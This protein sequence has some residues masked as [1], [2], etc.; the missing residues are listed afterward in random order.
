MKETIAAPHHP[1]RI[2]LREAVA[3]GHFVRQSDPNQYPIPGTLNAVLAVGQIVL[4]FALL[5]AAS[6]ASTL[7]VTALFA[8]AFAFF[9]QL[10][11]GL[12]HEAA[13]SKLHSRPAVNEGLGILS[14]SLFPGSY[15]LFEIAHLVHHR[16]NRSD[17]F[18]SRFR[19]RVA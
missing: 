5:G 7:W 15:H 4:S 19:C 10:G 12:A 14:Y 11:F 18:G 13:H 1:D 8:V 16:R 2:I 6:H 17:A 3:Q 9:M